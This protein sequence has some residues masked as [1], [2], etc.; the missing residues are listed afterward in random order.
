MS[1]SDAPAPLPLP[2]LRA[3]L[4]VDVHIAF[5]GLEWC[6][7]NDVYFVKFPATRSDGAVDTYLTKWTFFDYPGQPPHVTFVNPETKEYDPA[8]WPDAGNS[9]LSLAPE[10]GGAPEGLICNSMFYDWYYYGGHGD[11]PGVSW[12]PGVHKAIATVTE[13]RDVLRPPH[14][15]G[16]R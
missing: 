14:Y 4:A 5:A 16:P 10:Y 13:L 9:R 8:C 1:S 7:S 11:Q 3:I 15:R 12:K 2:Q 6:E